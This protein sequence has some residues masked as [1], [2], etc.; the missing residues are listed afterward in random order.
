MLKG[1]ICYKQER[2]LDYGAGKGEF[3]SLL[4]QTGLP[5][6]SYDPFFG[7][8]KTPPAHLKYS[9]VTCINA[10]QNIYDWEPVFADF[11]RLLVPGGTLLAF[12]PVWDNN[13]ETAG[14]LPEHWGFIAPARG[15]VCIASVKSL[16]TMSA[17]QGLNY[18]RESSNSFMHIFEKIDD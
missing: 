14:L 11:H 12:T 18:I 7:K 10:L 2:V 16:E 6:D 9:L 13:S 1:P 3:A 15:D 8:A 17:R 4:R 5:V